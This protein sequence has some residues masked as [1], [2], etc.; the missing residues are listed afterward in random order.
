MLLRHGVLKQSCLLWYCMSHADLSTTSC[1][2]AVLPINLNGGRVTAYT[3]EVLQ[4]NLE[5]QRLT[6]SNLMRG[7]PTYWY[8]SQPAAFHLALKMSCTARTQSSR[9]HR[10]AA[11]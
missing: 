1:E 7:A 9:A 10:R 3:G 6:L 4:G 8:V 11:V 2:L 5:F